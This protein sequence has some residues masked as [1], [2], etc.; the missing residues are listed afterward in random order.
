MVKHT[1]TNCLRVFDHY[2]RLAL[3]GLREDLIKK[4]TILKP[5]L[6]YVTQDILP[7]IFSRCKAYV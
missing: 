6:H 2:L 3:K 4:I 5:N 7:L 1:Q